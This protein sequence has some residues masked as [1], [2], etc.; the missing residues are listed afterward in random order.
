[1]HLLRKGSQ[2]V[3]GT[4]LLAAQQPHLLGKWAGLFEAKKPKG[5][6]ALRHTA[7]LKNVKYHHLSEVQIVVLQDTEWK[8]FNYSIQKREL[9]SELKG[10]K[11]KI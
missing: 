1:M 8:H 7:H 4:S 9:F 5:R 11:K 10:E 6:A 3:K 2:G